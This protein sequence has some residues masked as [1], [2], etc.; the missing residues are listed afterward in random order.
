MHVH[1]ASVGKVHLPN[2]HILLC[3][4]PENTAKYFFEPG[5][6]RLYSS[7]QTPKP[8]IFDFF[9]Y[10]NDFHVHKLQARHTYLIWNLLL[11]FCQENTTCHFFRPRLR[12][13]NCYKALSMLPAPPLFPFFRDFNDFHV[14]KISVD[15]A[16]LDIS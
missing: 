6:R 12:L 11:C 13:S 3:F 7:C 9:R 8:P 14:Q 5:L 2:R 1:E 4:Y 15:E 10:F 16:P